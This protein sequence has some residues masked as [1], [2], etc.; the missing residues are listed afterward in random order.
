M[1]T[2]NSSVKNEKYQLGVFYTKIYRVIPKNCVLIIRS[3]FSGS[4]VECRPEGHAW[5]APWKEAK[6]ISVAEKTIDYPKI[7][8]DDS[9]GQS[10]FVDYAITVK[11]IDSIKYEYAHQDP[12]QALKILL[13]SLIRVLM[14]KSSWEEMAGHQFELNRG[15]INTDI[16]VPEFDDEL[17]Y[18]RKRLDIFKNEYGLAV[19]SLVSKDIQQSPEMQK[20]YDE[21]KRKDKEGEALVAQAKR[22]KEKAEIDA[23]IRRTEADAKAYQQQKEALVN[24]QRLKLSIQAIKQGLD[25]LPIEQ[26]SRIVSDL[27]H[28]YLLTN[29][30]NPNT[31]IFASA[32]NADIFKA[33]AVNSL[34]KNEVTEAKGEAPKQKKK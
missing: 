21:K 26:V 23:E 29:G 28:T 8:F 15:G 24:A 27:A 14:R 34:P 4:K 22:N 9:E 3:K 12:E 2:Q 18:I 7:E 10:V 25:G 30:K 33:A 5:V 1:A 19:V 20:A 32:S 17:K 6:L 11:I 31:N 16:P 13:T